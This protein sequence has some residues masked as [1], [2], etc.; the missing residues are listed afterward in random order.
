MA[1]FKVNGTEGLD[2]TFERKSQLNADDLL[3]II[4][5]GA[6]LMRERLVEKVKTIFVQ[7]TGDLAHSFK[8]TERSND[9]DVAILVSPNGTRS[10]GNRGIRKSRRQG[11]HRKKTNA[12]IA[13][14]LEYGSARIKATHFM[15]H[16]A[17]EAENDVVAAMEAEYHRL[18]DERGL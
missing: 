9:G 16:T 7:H 18:L 17:E 6:E 3:R 12:E 10:S 14:V 15:Q 5:P 1:K 2:L 8:L 13:Y 4:H 11:K